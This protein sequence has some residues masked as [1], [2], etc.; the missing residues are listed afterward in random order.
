M[1]MYHLEICLKYHKDEVRQI[2]MINERTKVTKEQ[3]QGQLRIVVGLCLHF[4]SQTNV[5]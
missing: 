2:V 1:K 5:I 3:S 4:M